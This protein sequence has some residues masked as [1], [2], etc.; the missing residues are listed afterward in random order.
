ME[1]NIK[2]I[3]EE[4]HNFTKTSKYANI[5]REERYYG[6]NN[7]VDNINYRLRNISM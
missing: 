3:N 6:I 1:S 7:C 2:Q 5:E 4:I